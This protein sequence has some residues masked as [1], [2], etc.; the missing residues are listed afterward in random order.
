MIWRQGTQVPINVYDGDRPVC[1]CHNEED[2]KLICLAVNYWNEEQL[3]L[4]ARK[5]TK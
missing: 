5:E 4:D 2:A 1:Q 3:K